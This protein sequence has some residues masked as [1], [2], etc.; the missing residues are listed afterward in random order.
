MIAPVSARM[1]WRSALGVC[2][3][4][5]VV[6]AAAG[7]GAA[8]VVRPLTGRSDIDP[9]FAEFD[10]PD[11]PGCALGVIEAGEL[12][13]AR[14]YGEANL[15]HGTP[16]TP[17]SVFRVA[18]V[19]KQFTAMVV[20]LLDERGDLDLDDDIREWVPELPD[21]GRITIRHLLHHTSGLR[22]YLVLTRLA[23][24]RETDY[25]DARD[26][27]DLIS[28]QQALN[29]APGDAFRYSNTGYFLL[30]EI[31]GRAGGAPFEE[32][33]A[34]L[35]FE[36]LGMSRSRFVTDTAQ[37]I[38]G[39][40]YGYAPSDDGFVVAMTNLPIVG[41]GG[42]FTSVN[43]LVAW[44]RN[45]YDNRLGA[46]DPDLIRRWVTPGRLND[47][48]PAGF[49][50][51]GTYAAGI[52]LTEYRGVRR[53]AHGGAFV[54]FRADIARYPD[55]RTTVIT[56]C[57][58]ATAQ[59]SQL[60]ERVIDVLLSEVLGSAPAAAPAAAAEPEA[61]D[62]FGVPVS[63]LR[64]Y[65]GRYV[66]RELGVTYVLALREGRLVVE[67]PRDSGVLTARGEDL[68]ARPDWRMRITF[69]RNRAGAVDGFEVDAGRVS[70]LWFE[71][72]S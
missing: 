56:L 58:V 70:G 4:L 25:Y 15:E 7:C 62:D 10:R 9:I 61:E 30:A 5:P 21:L 43:D 6:L 50:S 19:S 48:E 68:F 45:F 11:S 13:H 37:V 24:Y 65:Q 42:L 32:L 55:S 18:S 59:P 52:A 72:V 29:F 36:P 35:I 54:G 1:A 40:A 12:T 41:D 53:V 66:S 64:E 28:R 63:E 22:D 46:G 26:L 23:G 67:R 31:A 3:A 34:E 60:G 71:R 14:G 47:G 69:R 51:G 16:L 57:N 44:D 27:L 2:V 20:L 17:D 8:E 38:P 39:R 49:A 33:A